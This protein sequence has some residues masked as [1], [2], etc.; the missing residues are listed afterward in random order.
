MVTTATGQN[1]KLRA[2]VDT[3]VRTNVITPQAQKRLGLE[4]THSDE[5]I[6]GE[7]YNNSRPVQ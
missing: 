5:R 2:L 4:E 6:V 1:I 7:I 3:C